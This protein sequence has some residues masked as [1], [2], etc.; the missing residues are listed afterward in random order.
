MIPVCETCGGWINGSNRATP[1]Y[2]S[3]R[4]RNEADVERHES[5]RERRIKSLHGRLVSARNDPRR[6][7]E[8]S[9]RLDELWGAG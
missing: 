7:D 2:C 8:I 6:L 4:C 5:K 9:R 3:P 1:G